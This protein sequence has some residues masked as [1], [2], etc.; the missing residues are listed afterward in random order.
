MHKQQ[1]RMTGRRFTLIE[2]AVAM[3]IFALL[4]LILMQIFSA[5]Q[6]VWRTSSGKAETYESARVVLDLLGNGLESAIRTNSSTGEKFYYKKTLTPMTNKTELWFPT[7]TAT[8]LGSDTISGEA[9]YYFMLD[10]PSGQ[11]LGTLKFGY[12]R[13]TSL[14][15]G[16]L[17]FRTNANAHISLD[18]GAETNLI[19]MLENVYEFKIDA[20]SKDSTGQLQYLSS[21]T[22]TELPAAVIVTLKVL[23]NDERTKTRFSNA[24]SDADREALLRTFRRII[25]VNATN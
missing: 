8:R 22:V 24:A 6:N 17:N 1:R 13:D 21:D 2:I 15:G 3:S 19:P 16:N 14:T 7:M 20:F 5:T 18:T 23:D 12:A 9:E 4:M 10:I 11:T 25:Y